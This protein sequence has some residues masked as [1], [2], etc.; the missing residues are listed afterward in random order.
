MVQPFP[1]LALAPPTPRRRTPTPAPSTDVAEVQ[2]D[3]V[4]AGSEVA[5]GSDT[6]ETDITINAALRLRNWIAQLFMIITIRRR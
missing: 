2:A 3:E 5:A 1:A 6:R 4:V